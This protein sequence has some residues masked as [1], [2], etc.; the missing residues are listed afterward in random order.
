MK[1]EVKQRAWQEIARQLNLENGKMVEQHWNNLKK[2]LSNLRMR[3][4]E[5]DVSAAAASSLLSRKSLEDLP[6]YFR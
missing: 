1:E 6:G 5:V 3:L 4:K 2:L